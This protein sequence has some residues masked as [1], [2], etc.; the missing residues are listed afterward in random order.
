MGENPAVLLPLDIVE[1][2]GLP[3]EQAFEKG[4]SLSAKRLVSLWRVDAGKPQF[5]INV[6]LSHD[7][8][9]VAV[10]DSDYTEALTGLDRCRFR[11]KR[12]CGWSCHPRSRNGEA[13]YDDSDTN[14]RHHE[15][16]NGAITGP[17][18]VSK[19]VRI[20]HFPVVTGAHS[21]DL[22]HTPSVSAG[23]LIKTGR[24]KPAEVCP[25]V[26][27]VSSSVARLRG[28]SSSGHSRAGILR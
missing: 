11:G 10:L 28:A 26:C 16:G 9:G 21:F 5:Q 14:E 13:E 19:A 7:N 17:S 24:T 3:S 25:L 2:N 20:K 1:M 23:V 27:A 15:P 18:C 22:D 8:D 12:R 6:V 4:S